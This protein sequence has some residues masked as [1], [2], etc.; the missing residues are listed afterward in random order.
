MRYDFFEWR[1]KVKL[2][3]GTKLPD[4]INAPVFA[5]LKKIGCNL[6]AVKLLKYQS[7]CRCGSIEIFS[8][9]VPG[10]R[11]VIDIAYGMATG[12]KTFESGDEGDFTVLDFTS[13]KNKNI[14]NKRKKD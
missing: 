6:A 4:D 14:N 12:W 13:V 7:S 11:I 5:E 9:K 2:N 3:P 10:G 1:D 8:K